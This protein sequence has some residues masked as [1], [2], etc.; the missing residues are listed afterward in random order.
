M[1][2]GGLTDIGAHPISPVVRMISYK[3]TRFSAILVLVVG[4]E[5]TNICVLSAAP[6]PIGLHKYIKVV[7]LVGFEPTLDGF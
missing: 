7:L 6:L 1:G 2:D 4:F 3:I 5:P